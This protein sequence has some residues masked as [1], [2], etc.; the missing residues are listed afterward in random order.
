MNSYELVRSRRVLATVILGNCIMLVVLACGCVAIAKWVT[1]ERLAM[2]KT[3]RKPPSDTDNCAVRQFTADGRSVGRCWHYVRD[4][5]CPVHDDVRAVQDHYART[6]E[7]T[8]ER[9]R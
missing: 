8:D 1:T 3:I 5:K 7:L 2:T 9:K 6:G 4:G